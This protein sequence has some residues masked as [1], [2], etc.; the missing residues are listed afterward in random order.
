MWWEVGLGRYRRVLRVM[1]Y[2]V[3]VFF[4]VLLPFS[5]E[6]GIT[7]FQVVQPIINIMRDELVDRFSRLLSVV[8]LRVPSA[9][10]PQPLT[11][12]SR[13]SERARTRT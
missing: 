3:T 7:V 13:Q 11:V 5:I 8:A 4:Q 2:S 10:A 1:V 6:V 9:P 12:S